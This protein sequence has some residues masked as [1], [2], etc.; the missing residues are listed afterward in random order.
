MPP[1]RLFVHGAVDTAEALCRA[2]KNLGWTTIVADARRAFATP[3]ACRAP[4][5]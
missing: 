5:S 4:T 1:P 3:S 2:A